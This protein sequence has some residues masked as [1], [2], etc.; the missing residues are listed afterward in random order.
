MSTQVKS[1]VALPNDS[2]RRRHARVQRAARAR[3]RRV[4]QT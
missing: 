3:V 4:H 2:R 1:T